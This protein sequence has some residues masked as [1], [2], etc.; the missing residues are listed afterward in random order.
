[1]KQP[2]S[3]SVR[4]ADGV[5]VELV[6]LGPERVR[7]APPVLLMAGTFSSRAFWLGTRGQGLGRLLADRGFDCWVLEP[8]GHG[9]SE[10]PPRWTMS[11]WIGLDAPAAVETVLRETRSEELFWVGHSAGGVVGTAF[12]GTG[13]ALARAVRGL[14][15]LATPGPGRM[16]IVR[17]LGAGAA[18]LAA[19]LLPG[20]S[21]SG[22]WLGLGPEPE[23]AS[24]VREWMGWNFAGAWRGPEGR[25]Y[26]DGLPR[27]PAPVLAVAGAGDRMLAPP[28]AVRDLAERFGSADV[29][30]V[31]AGRRTGYAADYGHADL[32]VK[33]SAREEVWPVVARWLTERAESTGEPGGE[34]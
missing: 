20:M 4:A 33:P 12:A 22:E 2:E 26:L 1:M 32:V 21:V 34:R 28:H 24:L 23:P 14:V 3:H 8:R 30:T 16:G 6:R 11:D 31:T 25:D 13:S 9:E 15:L 29:T 17:R 7:W 5:R 18:S 19:G 27:I 10:R